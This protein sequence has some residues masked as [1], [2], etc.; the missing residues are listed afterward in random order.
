MTENNTTTLVNTTVEVLSTVVDT[1]FPHVSTDKFRRGL[2]A[3]AIDGTTGEVVATDGHSLAII[4]VADSATWVR[5]PVSG[6]ILLP[7]KEFRA[8]LVAARKQT[9]TKKWGQ[10][11]A[12]VRVGHDQWTLVVGTSTTSGKLV[13]D[14]P[15]PNWRAVVPAEREDAPPY[16]PTGWGHAVLGAIAASL[17]AFTDG[18]A[19]QS[20]TGPLDPTV[21][22]AKTRLG[23]G[24]ASL[25]ILGMPMRA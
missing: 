19:V 3:L 4:H 8:A 17:A 20:W 10:T 21:F 9:P 22:R 1:C 13:V 7:A 5:T 24:E 12:E 15:F 2:T 23:D 14:G 11:R 25:M 16:Q 6:N 18:P